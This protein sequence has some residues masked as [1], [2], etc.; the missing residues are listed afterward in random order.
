M[1]KSYKVIRSERK[2]DVREKEFSLKYFSSV[3]RK[4]VTKKNS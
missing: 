3:A 1:Q 2:L 4:A